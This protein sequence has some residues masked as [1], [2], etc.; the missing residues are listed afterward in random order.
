MLR[1]R[2]AAPGQ[3]LYIEYDPP[4]A[5]DG[6]FF[7]ETGRSLRGAFLT[8]WQ[9]RGGVIRFGFPLTDELIEPEVGT[10][11]PRVVQYFERA[12]FEHYPEYSG[13]PGEVRSDSLSLGRLALQRA[14]DSGTTVP[15]E[16][17][18]GTCRLFDVAAGETVALCPPFRAV[19]ERYAE[20]AP[21]GVPL[22]NARV[23]VVPQSDTPRLVQYF[24]H[25]RL[26]YFPEYAGTPFEVQFGLLGRELFTSVGGMP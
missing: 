26:E 7:Q 17:G 8:Y 10:G 15:P 3:P 6:L 24:T 13:S 20:V 22:A 1:L 25:A 12:R 2:A 4:T 14:V 19:W 5:R 9:E 21:L 18:S 16:R 11:R 23:V